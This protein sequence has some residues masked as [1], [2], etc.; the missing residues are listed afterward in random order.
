MKKWVLLFI[1]TFFISQLVHSQEV[2]SY[3]FYDNL[4]EFT[5]NY[6]AL[7]I[8]GDKGDFVTEVVPRLGKTPRQVY[9]FPRSSGLIFDYS[10][11]KNFIQG[12]Y[13]VEMYFRYD[14]ADLLMYGVIIGENS[15]ARQGEFVHLVTT[16]DSTTKTVNVFLDGKLKT[17]FVDSNDQLAIEPN[18]QFIFFTKDDAMTTSGG[19]AMIKIYNSFIDTEKAKLLFE[20]FV[21]EKEVEKLPALEKEVEKPPVTGKKITLE[22]L[23]FVQS[24]AKLLPE[25]IPELESLRKL[26]ETNPGLKIA[27]Y[28][29]TD[30][31]GDFNL[32]LK[33]SRERAE[34]VK[35]FLIE[36]GIQPDRIVTKG[37]GSTRPVASNYQEETRQLN[38]RVEMEVTDQ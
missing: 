2:A 3:Y 25:S 34:S 19:V 28:G 9:Q 4:N 24:E 7:A 38:R 31:Q 30:N 36:N 22:R 37:Y 23:F 11:V 27:L 1:I 35:T 17:T 20:P 26:M 5:S 12:S 29:H 15:E 13:A 10:N 16:R 6:P 18:A 21:L 14:N 33:L 8:T 32:N